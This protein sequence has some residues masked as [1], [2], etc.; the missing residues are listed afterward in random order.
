M[1]L[2]GYVCFDLILTDPY[3]ILAVVPSMI[4]Y[5]RAILQYYYNTTFEKEIAQIDMVINWK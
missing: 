5:N 1:L 4:V 2:F 3:A